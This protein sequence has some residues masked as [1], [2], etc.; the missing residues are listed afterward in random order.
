MHVCTLDL[1]KT[2]KR[3]T[4]SCCLLIGGMV[5]KRAHEVCEFTQWP[6]LV[7]RVCGVEAVLSFKPPATKM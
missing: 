2:S 6:K 3:G 7:D 4:S 5:I 1:L